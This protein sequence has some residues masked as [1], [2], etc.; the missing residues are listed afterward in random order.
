MNFRIFHFARRLQCSNNVTIIFFTEYTYYRI[1][2]R[3]STIKRKPKLL[4]MCRYRGKNEI[5]SNVQLHTGYIFFFF[6]Y[7]KQGF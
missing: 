7:T 1:G 2:E 5:L 6:K 4:Y 3:I